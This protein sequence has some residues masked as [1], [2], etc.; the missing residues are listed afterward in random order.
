MWKETSDGHSFVCRG[1][2]VCNIRLYGGGMYHVAYENALK[3]WNADRLAPLE[4]LKHYVEQEFSSW[5][6]SC[7]DEVVKS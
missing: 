5:L 3:L 6:K 7:V 1:Q 2:T 4:E